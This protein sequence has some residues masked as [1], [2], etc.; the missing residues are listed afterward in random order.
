MLESPEYL[1]PDRQVYLEELKRV[2]K[3]SKK[4]ILIGDALCSDLKPKDIAM[5]QNKSDKTIEYQ[6][7][8]LFRILNIHSTEELKKIWPFVKRLIEDIEK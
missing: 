2:K 1:N 6:K 4:E 5:Q 3:L 7:Q 8:L